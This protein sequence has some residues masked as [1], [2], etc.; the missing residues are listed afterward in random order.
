MTQA[1]SKRQMRRDP[2]GVVTHILLC[3]LKHLAL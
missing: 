1:V 2:G 3:K